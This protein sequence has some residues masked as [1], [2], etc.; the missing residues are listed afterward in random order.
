MNIVAHQDDDLLFMNPDLL[1]EL[2]AGDCVRTI[3]VT[4][5]DAGSSKSYWL[6]REQGSEAAY[7]SM[8]GIKGIWIQRIVEL[9]NHEFIS[10]ANPQG[11]TKVSL[12]FM[13]LPDGNLK[14]NGFSDSHFESLAKL[15][16]GQISTMNAIDG[17]STYTLNQ[18]SSALTTLMHLYQPAE[19]HTQSNYVSATFPDHSD[20]MAVGRLVQGSYNRYETE[21]YDN[22]VIIPLMFYTGYPIHGFPA[23]VSGAN[24]AA[25]EAAFLSYAKFDSGVCQS[26]SKCL[27]TPTYEAYLTR[28]YQELY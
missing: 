19:I 24:L 20:H 1:N 2:E 26:I 10:V 6:S 5:G 17:Q 8:L 9:S 15:E 21:Q 16:A 28:Q 25:K 14:G 4:A 23:N 7:A 22:V 18:L 27:Q 12:I 11:N 3:Y 13:R